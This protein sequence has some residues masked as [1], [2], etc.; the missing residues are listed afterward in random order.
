VVVLHDYACSRTGGALRL[1]REVRGAQALLRAPHA[2]RGGGGRY[3][4]D[5]RDLPGGKAVDD[6]EEHGGDIV[7]AKAGERAAQDLGL[8]HLILERDGGVES[9][10]LGVGEALQRVPRAAPALVAQEGDGAVV[11]DAIEPAAHAGLVRVACEWRRQA[12]ARTPCRDEHLLRDIE[13]V[14]LV[15]EQPLDEASQAAIVAREQIFEV[16]SAATL[17]CCPLAKPTGALGFYPQN[18]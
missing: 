11:G 7:G 4:E 6:V 12:V 14:L 3:V 18:A 17:P 15:V 2:F 9:L 13:G 16:W 5:L 8:D 1:L 10:L